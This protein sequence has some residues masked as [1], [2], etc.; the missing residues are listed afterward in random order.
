MSMELERRGVAVSR[1]TGR[2]LARI[3]GEQLAAQAMVHARESVVAYEAYCRIENGYELA[4]QA[5]HNATQLSR[6]VT[7]ATRD[8]PGLEMELRG[9]E[10]D[11]ALAARSIVYRYMT[12]P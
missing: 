11:V 4:N 3:R 7:Q 12:R 9:L 2:E 5:V 10:Q 8:K 6:E 1:S